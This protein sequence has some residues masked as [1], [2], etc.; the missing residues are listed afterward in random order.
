MKLLDYCDCR[1]MR[2][3]ARSAATRTVPEIRSAAGAAPR[4]RP[5]PQAIELHEPPTYIRFIYDE[6]REITFYSEQRRYVR[7]ET[8]ANS[9]YHDPNDAHRS[10]IN[11]IV[12]GDLALRGSTALKDGRMRAII[13][14]LNS[15]QLGR[16][17]TI[18]VELRSAPAS[19]SSWINVPT[20]LSKP[21][22]PNPLGDK[23]RRLLSE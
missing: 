9:T 6:D 21:Q 12:D 13:E 16:T 8:D 14:G 4:P 5:T 10:N 15:A 7:I 19:Q 18:R 20:A 22:E 17:G 23:S 3:E 11:I 1:G 2:W